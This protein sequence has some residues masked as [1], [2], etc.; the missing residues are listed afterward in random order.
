MSFS[1]WGSEDGIQLII[2]VTFS[3]EIRNLKGGFG[4]L[5]MLSTVCG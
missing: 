4:F 3:V 2:N 1:L 5:C